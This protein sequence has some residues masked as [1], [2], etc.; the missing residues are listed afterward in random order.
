MKQFVLVLFL[1]TAG[2]APA[3]NTISTTIGI[4]RDQDGSVVSDTSLWAIVYDQDNNGT[5]AGGLEQNSSL[6][7]SDMID[8]LTT[9][10]NTTIE[11]G[12]TVGGDLILAVLEIDS[13]NTTGVDGV[14]GSDLDF[15]YAAQGLTAGRNWAIYWFPGLTMASNTL[16]PT[17]FSI[18]GIH[19]NSLLA[20][21]SDTTMALPGG[22][23]LNL[24]LA[25][26]DNVDPVLIGEGGQLPVSRLTAIPEPS[27]AFLGLVGLGWACMVRRRTT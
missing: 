2:I 17:G 27:A 7:A 24:T 15:D 4:L 19:E 1:V 26:Y 23:G 14:A 18:G 21:G 10:A 12:A 16:G 8:A 13:F 11:V 5:F 25:L 3:A 9:W 6:T 20:S 22:D